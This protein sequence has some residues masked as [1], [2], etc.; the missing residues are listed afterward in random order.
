MYLSGRG[1]LRPCW[2]AQVR[3]GGCEHG[4]SSRDLHAVQHGNNCKMT[5][6]AAPAFRGI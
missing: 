4:V 6:T 2:L 3:A 5:S 1:W